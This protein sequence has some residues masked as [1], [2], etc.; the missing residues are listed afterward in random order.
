MALS[1]SLASA[2]QL[3]WKLVGLPVKPSMQILQSATQQGQSHVVVKLLSSWLEKQDWRQIC[4]P[5]AAP[6][7][8]SLKMRKVRLTLYCAQLVPGCPGCATGPRAATK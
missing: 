6:C 7:C 3:E 8:A 2:E 1:A 4:M 5:W